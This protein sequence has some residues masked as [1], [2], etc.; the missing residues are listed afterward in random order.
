[1]L[2]CEPDQAGLASLKSKP[3]QFR[4]VK[5]LKCKICSNSTHVFATATLLTRYKVRYFQCQ[6][7]QFVQTE[8]PYWLEMAYTDAISELDVGLPRRNRLYSEITSNLI[9]AVFD[10]SASYLDYGCGYGLFVRYMRDQ[11]FDFYGYDKYCR[12][13]FAQRFAIDIPNRVVGELLTSFEVF[14][15]LSNPLEEIE[16][17]LNMAPN[18]FFSTELLPQHSPK[19]GDWW[20]Y[21][22][23]SG[24]HISFYTY[25]SLLQIARKFDLFL[26]SDFKSLHLL[27]KKRMP[28]WFFKIVVNR[29]S[30]GPLTLLLKARKQ[31]YSL[32]DEDILA[33]QNRLK[34][35]SKNF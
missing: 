22:L 26:Y 1:M 13:I 24:Q 31:R 28:N 4:G 6:S 23:D 15:H 21:A 9:L 32:L 25:N 10:P 35:G 16:T 14:E 27:S 8:E 29:R 17:M 11:G 20:Y 3:G 34:E 2:D 18:L 7:C 33:V 30:H 5:N 19:P 12:N